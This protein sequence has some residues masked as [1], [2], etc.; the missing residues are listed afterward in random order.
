MDIG[1][2]ILAGGQ[3]RRMG[4]TKALLRLHPDGPRLIELVCA[5]VQPLADEIVVST[6]TPADFAWLGLPLVADAVP[7]AGPLAGLAAGLAA[8]HSEW[9]LL[10]ACDMPF[11]VTDVLRYLCD[12]RRD[13]LAAVVPLNPAGRP[14]PLCA[15]Y[16]R[17]CLPVL[18]QHL[19]AGDYA[20]QAWLAQVPTRF[21]PAA[22]LLPLDPDLRTFRNLNTPE[23]LAEVELS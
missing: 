2:I 11:L 10:V 12:Q 20:M 9:G 3:S 19:A 14:E 17:A 15:L 8:L 16:H 23:D 5:A 1:A 4:Q 22:D 6:N 18:R 13:D 7:G 21:I